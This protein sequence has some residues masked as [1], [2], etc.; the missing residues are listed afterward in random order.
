MKIILLLCVAAFSATAQNG[1]PYRPIGTNRTSKIPDSDL[2][3]FR[4]VAGQAYNTQ[5]SVLWKHFE[6][7]CV[8]V[9]T[10]GAILEELKYNRS[11]V[12]GRVDYNQSIGAYGSA[13][14]RR[15]IS[16][17]RI[18]GKHFFLTNFPQ[19]LSDKQIVRGLAMQTGTVKI[20][21]QTI[22]L[23]DYGTP[24]QP[25]PAAKSE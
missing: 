10:N 11:Y 24:Y 1:I 22:E 16:E 21:H 3:V 19:P 8:E 12:A 14:A 4:V 17:T 9:L 6:A 15:M 13:P 7:E 25:K 5:K 20:G 2:P 18:P 23:W